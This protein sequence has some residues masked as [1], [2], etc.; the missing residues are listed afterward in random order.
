VQDLTDTLS[1]L[2]LGI[3]S[4]QIKFYIA[5]EFQ[6]I[7]ENTLQY[8]THVAHRSSTTCLVAGGMLGGDGGESRVARAW[9]LT[10]ARYLGNVKRQDGASG[11]KSR[12]A[13]VPNPIRHGRTGITDGVGTAL[14]L[15]GWV[16]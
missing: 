4:N 2:L 7:L 3:K 6:R 1:N 14:G 11:D 15:E 5:Y 16:Q 8:D 12:N 9:C 13:S 10:F